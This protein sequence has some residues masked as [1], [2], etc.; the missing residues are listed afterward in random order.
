VQ[1]NQ[2]ATNPDLLG[3]IFDAQKKLF[4]K[5]DDSASPGAEPPSA[6]VAK[7]CPIVSVTVTQPKSAAIK[8]PNAV[9]A[10]FL[11]QKVDS[12]A[13]LNKLTPLKTI[14]RPIVVEE[15]EI[16]VPFEGEEAKRI[17]HQRHQEQE[18]RRR[19]NLEIMAHDQSSA[20]VSLMR[21]FDDKFNSM[22]PSERR[23][24]VEAKMNAARN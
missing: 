12:S 13:S 20:V 7:N 9:A 4:D 21:K 6:F 19:L 17:Q 24:F 1:K 11:H 23:Q 18:R 3:S 5:R 8:T 2:Q 22:T 10:D 14:K 15:V 16:S